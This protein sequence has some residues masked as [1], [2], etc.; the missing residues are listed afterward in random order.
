MNEKLIAQLKAWAALKRGDPVPCEDQDDWAPA[1]TRLFNDT[2]AEMER[3]N[4]LVEQLTA[5]RNAWNEMY[6]RSSNTRRVPE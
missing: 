2:I 1:L 6:G 5:D 4:R 3:L